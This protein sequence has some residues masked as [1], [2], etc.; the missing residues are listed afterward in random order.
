[1]A[2]SNEQVVAALK[3][4]PVVTGAVVAVLLLAVALYFRLDAVGDA[5]TQLETKSAEGQRLAANIKNSA[6]LPEQ[7]AELVAANKEIENRLV[8]VGQ[9]ASNLQYFYKL[10]A[11]TGT[12]FLDLRQVTVP[13]RGP[14]KP[15]KIPVVFTLTVQGS[16]QQIF[17]F[18]RRLESGVHYCRVVSANFTPVAEAGAATAVRGDLTKL[19]LNLELLGVP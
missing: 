5:T 16:Y 6:Q 2:L 14:A 18:L 7:L 15:G 17:D 4:N 3:K 9:L 19:T 11:D 1:M 13:S 10:E 8:R 12:K